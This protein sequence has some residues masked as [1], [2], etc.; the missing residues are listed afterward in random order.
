M[1]DQS[2]P[3]I[4]ISAARAATWS[5]SRQDACLNIETAAGDLFNGLDGKWSLSE[6]LAQVEGLSR[7]AVERAF[8]RQDQDVSINE[9][10]TL[11]DASTV[12]LVGSFVSDGEARGLVLRE[13]GKFHHKLTGGEG[14]QP[15]FQPIWS[16]STR[17]L[18]GFEALARWQSPEDDDLIGPE[19]LPRFGRVADWTSIAPSILSEA[20]RALARFRVETGDVFV[21]VNLSAVEI[22]RADLVN[23]VHKFIRECDLPDGVLRIELTEQAALRDVDGALGVMKSF[24]DAGAG[25]ILDDFGAGHSSLAWLADVPA[26]GIKLDSQ[27]TAKMAQ[28]RGRTILSTIVDLAHR[29]GMTVTAEGVETMEAAR[30]LKE[31]GCDFVQGY[32]SGQPMGEDQIVEHLRSLSGP[33]VNQ[34]RPPST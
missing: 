4:A 31:I 3:A 24:R 17:R 6:F 12:R 23:D 7:P 20:A 18:A 22:A 11:R 16:T 25:V 5:W 14:V 1:V 33:F 32:L 29:L 21:Q 19:E 27:L 30:D 9:L 26:D 28:P 8:L 13:G 34:A 15:V 2:L 10:I